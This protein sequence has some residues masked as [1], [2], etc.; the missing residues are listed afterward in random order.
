MRLVFFNELVFFD[1][2]NL[3]D[4]SI[5]EESSKKKKK[6]VFEFTIELCFEESDERKSIHFDWSSEDIIDAKDDI[7]CYCFFFELIFLELRFS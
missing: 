5:I 4:I 7:E 3:W 1:E 6:F 2:L